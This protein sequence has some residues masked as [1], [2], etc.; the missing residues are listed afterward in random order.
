MTM[1]TEGVSTRGIASS[2]CINCG[3]DMFKVLVKVSPEGDITWFTANGY[4]YWCKA[5]V[6]IPTPTQMEFE[7]DDE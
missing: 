1:P 3:N 2:E 6:T 5:P 4:C 7:F